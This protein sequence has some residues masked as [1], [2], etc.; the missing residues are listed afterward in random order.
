MNRRNA[1]RRVLAG[2][3][4]TAA[5][6]PGRAA[7]KDLE[8]LVAR[9]EKARAFTLQVADAMP[10]EGYDFKPKPGMRP[11]GELLQ[12]IATNNAFY[13][14]RFKAGAI[15]DSLAPPEKF[16]KETTKKYLAASFDFCAGVL[17][18][19]TEGDLDKSY[20]GR[21]NT[22]PQTGWDWVLHAFIHTAHHRGYAEVYLRENNITPPRYSV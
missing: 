6:A 9:W 1:I 21:P 5:A 17:K 16:D 3:A 22:P 8:V 15:P 7:G 12:H 13:I 14:S 19:I 2:A 11:Y 10:P 18:A 4:A 20:P